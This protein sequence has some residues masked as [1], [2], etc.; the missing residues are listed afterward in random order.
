[1]ENA[2]LS[3]WGPGVAVTGPATIKPIF[4]PTHSRPFMWVTSL[5]PA[6]SQTAS[7]HLP[8]VSWMDQGMCL[9]GKYLHFRPQD[10][11]F[12]C[13]IGIKKTANGVLRETQGGV[14]GF[15]VEV[16]P[17]SQEQGHSRSSEML[18]SATIT[19]LLHFH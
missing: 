14:E 10:V 17:F 7:G 9:H 5:F 3:H 1:M 13:L 2:V 8:P 11:F 19:R 15:P 16:Y 18:W 6:G 4:S 12:L